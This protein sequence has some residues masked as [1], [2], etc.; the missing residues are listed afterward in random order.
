M[1]PGQ[2]E[3]V[4]GTQPTAG[5]GTGWAGFK[6][7]SN[8]SHSTIATLLPQLSCQFIADNSLLPAPTS[9]STNR[10]YVSL[11]VGVIMH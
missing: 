1:D 4:G 7:P 2:P 3:L 11:K 5:L 6:E 9:W 8:L 10:N